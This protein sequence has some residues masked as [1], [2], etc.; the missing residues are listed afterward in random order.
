MVVERLDSKNED[1][2][3]HALAT[4]VQC[5]SR[6]LIK[7]T[8]GECKRRAEYIQAGL[9]C[10]ALANCECSWDMVKRIVVECG[11]VKMEV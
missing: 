4:L 7:A 5:I 9:I 3:H 6:S 1:L 10:T 8:G 2:Y 11:T